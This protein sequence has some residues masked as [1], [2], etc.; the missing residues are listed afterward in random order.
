MSYLHPL[1]FSSTFHKH[2]YLTNTFL[3]NSHTLTFIFYFHYT[4]CP[5]D[6]S[7]LLLLFHQ[8]N[9]QIINHLKICKTQIL[10]FHI[11]SSQW[12]VAFF[13]VHIVSTQRVLQK[14]GIS[15]LRQYVLWCS[16]YAKDAHGSC[17]SFGYWFMQH[18]FEI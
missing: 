7:P 11:V 3:L 16:W 18:S 9:Q 15:G 14:T 2:H 17:A 5:N 6:V 10:A 12:F 4:V 1:L 8:S 13:F